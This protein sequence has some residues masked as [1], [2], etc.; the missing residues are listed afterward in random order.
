MGE[1][2]PEI[3][4][5]INEDRMEMNRRMC[6]GYSWC[7]GILLIMIVVALVGDL[8]LGV[9]FVLMVLV[10]GA[11][12]GVSVI[13]R[14]KS[15]LSWSVSGYARQERDALSKKNWDIPLRESIRFY[16][17]LIAMFVLTQMLVGVGLDLSMSLM[18]IGMFTLNGGVAGISLGIRA[19]QPGQISCK[20]CSY[21]LTGLTLPCMCPECGGSIL[22]G[23]FTTDRPKVQWPW[24]WRGGIVLVVFGGLLSYTSIARPGMFY[25]VLPKAALNV[26]ASGDDAAFEQL[27]QTSMTPEQKVRLIDSLIEQARGDWLGSAK[28]DWLAAC[29][30]DGSMQPNQFEAIMEMLPPIRIVA[31]ETGKVGEPIDLIL[32]S[33]VPSLVSRSFIPQY[34]FRGFVVGD[35]PEFHQGS[36]DPQSWHS[37]Y[38]DRLKSMMPAGTV[39]DQLIHQLVP[40]EAGSVVVRARVVLV[41]TDFANKRSFSWD[42]QGQGVFADEPE[43]MKTLDLEIVIEVDET[44]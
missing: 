10:L 3:Q 24:L 8:A 42:E 41:V 43:W 21:P 39:T 33:S 27:I 25:S 31:P 29:V 37:L 19:R 6:R 36:E 20:K 23:R 12:I 15:G 30:Q 2:V 4:P 14:K 9:R 7:I 38:M 40:R 22:D 11:W 16:L 13:A 34:F 17:L 35:D 5:R 44:D 32:G 1:P 26:M 28:R 18:Y